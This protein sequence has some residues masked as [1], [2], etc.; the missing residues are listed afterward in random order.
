MSRPHTSSARTRTPL[1][2]RQNVVSNNED[3][4]SMRQ[5]SHSARSLQGCSSVKLDTA[6]IK[7]LNDPLRVFRP[8][9]PSD[10]RYEVRADVLNPPILP[11]YIQEPTLAP[12]ERQRVKPENR[13]SC[14]K[15]W[16]ETSQQAHILERSQ[17]VSND[18]LH[19]DAKK[20]LARSFVERNREQLWKY[21]LNYIGKTPRTVC[22]DLLESDNFVGKMSKNVNRERILKLSSSD[23]TMVALTDPHHC[24]LV[25][26]PHGTSLNTSRDARKERMEK[27]LAP[28]LLQHGRTNQRGFDHTV[29]FGNF[30]KYNGYVKMNVATVMNR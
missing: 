18:K 4:H 13:L 24:D 7:K 20:Q 15:Q 9:T 16:L 30:S 2:G 12:A 5:K 26:N 19:D 14:P 6:R 1:T 10:R 29:G 28:A 25:Y 21:D 3:A 8:F 22:R 17:F 27:L 11:K 23:K